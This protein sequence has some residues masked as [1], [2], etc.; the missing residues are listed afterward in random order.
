MS[1]KIMDVTIR[2]STYIENIFLNEQDA[3]NIIDGLS[4]S[5]IDFIEIGYVSTHTTKNLFKSCSP[6][7]INTLGKHLCNKKTKLVLM[8]YPK[9]YTDKF[10]DCFLNPYVGLVRL[11]ISIDNIYTSIPLIHKLKKYNIPVSANLT[12]ISKLS[13]KEIIQYAH[14][15]EKAGADY[16]YLA[17]SNGA[18]LPDEITTLFSSLRKETNIKLG[19]HPH[20]N[21][22]TGTANSLSAIK[23]GVN[24][25]DASLYGYGKGLANLPLQSFI[26]IIKKLKLRNDIN[27][28]K[29]I[30]TSNKLYNDK[31]YSGFQKYL[32][33]RECNILTG[34]YNI[35]FD[36]IKKLQHEAV[37]KNINFIDVLLSNVSNQ[38]ITLKGCQ[39]YE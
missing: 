4:S 9:D 14:L 34:Y 23:N 3:I 38:N 35:N 11:C 24:I 5:N 25:V 7:L 26:A 37:S 18:M 28:G 32:N 16:V 12:R 8:M 1:L 27:L 31:L 39:L 20:D 29:I 21:L 17:D 2:E 10:L 36:F 13:L 30:Q 33:N 6:N 22:R 19:F 15:F